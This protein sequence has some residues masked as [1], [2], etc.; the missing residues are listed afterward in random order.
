MDAG[1]KDAAAVAT[2]RGDVIL[3]LLQLLNWMA[4][5]LSIRMATA[6]CPTCQWT[7]PPSCSNSSR[8]CVVNHQIQPNDDQVIIQRKSIDGTYT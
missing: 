4:V 1:G 3:D 2:V 6:V 7:R 8:W 5:P